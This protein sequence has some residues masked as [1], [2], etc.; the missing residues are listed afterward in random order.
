M[1]AVKNIH[2]RTRYFSEDFGLFRQS[3]KFHSTVMQKFS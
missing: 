3:L 2:D 1:E